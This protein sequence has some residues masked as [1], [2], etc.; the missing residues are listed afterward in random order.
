MRRKN[1]PKGYA[2]MLEKQHNQLV[3]GLQEMYLRLRKANLWEGE[4]LDESSGRPLT[5]DILAALNSLDPQ[6]DGSETE[7]IE[8]P[9]SSP[10]FQE[11]DAGDD[12]DDSDDDAQK[13]PVHSSQDLSQPRPPPHNHPLFFDSAALAPPQTTSGTSSEAILISPAPPS[14]HHPLNNQLSPHQLSTVPTSPRHIFPAL[15]PPEPIFSDLLSNDPLYT[16][17]TTQYPSSSATSSNFDSVSST[18]W[19][20]SM[21]TFPPLTT[22][23]P[24]SGLGPALYI[25]NTSALFQKRAALASHRPSLCHTWL[26]GGVGFDSSDFMGD[27]HQFSPQMLRFATVE[28]RDSLCRV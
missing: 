6:A 3:S 19:F 22:Q 1:L 9:Y 8:Q 10:L 25:D 2:E 28:C 5:H 7:F 27:L 24:G 23:L 17:D 20:L 21:P 12:D 16:Y 4:L 26:G 11:P 15:S 14:P 18:D 13:S